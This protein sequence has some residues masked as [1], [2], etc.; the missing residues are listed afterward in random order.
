MESAHGNYGSKKS[1]AH[2]KSN[3]PV[4]S[5]SYKWNRNTV[6]SLA[7][8]DLDFDAQWDNNESVADNRIL[9]NIEILSFE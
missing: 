8:K 4:P 3:G 6:L 7:K 2:K 5:D 1:L 9:S